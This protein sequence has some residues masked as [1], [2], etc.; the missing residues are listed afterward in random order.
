V[1]LDLTHGLAALRRFNVSPTPES[2]ISMRPLLAAPGK[3]IAQWFGGE[4]RRLAG[5]R[6]ECSTRGR[7]GNRRHSHCGPGGASTP[8]QSPTA[9]SR[10]VWIRPVVGYP[11]PSRR[12]GHWRKSP[13]ALPAQ[14]APAG[15]SPQR[16]RATLQLTDAR[17]ASGLHR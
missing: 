16:C 5:N 3:N 12:I 6:A 9:L 13:G 11:P 8:S 10:A 7:M 2:M 14:T 17:R 15:P 1:R 4:G